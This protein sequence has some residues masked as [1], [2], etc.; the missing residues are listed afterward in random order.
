M[1]QA[2]T[3]SNMVESAA[4][5]ATGFVSQDNLINLEDTMFSQFSWTVS[6]AEF[7]PAYW[8]KARDEKLRQFWHSRGAG[9]LASAVYSAQSKLSSIPF[10]VVARDPSIASHVDE[11]AATEGRL[12]NLSE[13]GQG[14]EVTMSKFYEDL[15]STDN[16]G[17]IEVIGAGAPNGP[18]EGQ[19][20]ALRHLDSVRCT[21]TG[22]PVYPVRYRGDD[23]I[24]RKMHFSRIIYVSQMPSPRREL[25]G[26]GY[27]AVS[28]ALDFGQALMDV[29]LY[30]REKLGSR[31]TD[32]ILLGKGIRGED[33]M[34]TM[35]AAST[36][37]E[38]NGAKAGYW[39]ALGSDATDVGIEKVSLK[40]MDGMDETDVTAMSM[41]AI[42][43]AFGM[44]PSDLWPLDNASSKAG[45][46]VSLMRSRGKLPVQ[47][48]A[49]VEREFAFKV[50]PTYLKV[51]FSYI[52]DEEDKNR[53][54]VADIRARMRHR[55]MDAGVTNIQFERRRMMVSGDMSREE[56]VE[57]ELRDGR[58]ETG[59]PVTTLF[60][61]DNPVLTGPGGL[62][63]IGVEN[64]LAVSVN[65][66][67]KTIVA[68]NLSRERVLA[69]MANA[70][71]PRDRRT[72]QEAWAAINVLLQMYDPYFDPKLDLKPPSSDGNAENGRVDQRTER[73]GF[74]DNVNGGSV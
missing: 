8:S 27:C 57:A 47:V 1:A 7:V 66:I 9:H 17:F 3:Q 58:L 59:L 56:F 16:G 49:A 39:V 30:K 22:N 55:N 31:P 35:R 64:P 21:R 32:G 41:A 25:Y 2:Q 73:S 26:V 48:M 71:S 43:L 51:E 60:F 23:G 13:F 10:S 5:M 6:A 72:G 74:R 42:A 40:S 37:V 19:P 28:R 34:K 12:R 29:T 69:Y 11:A 20:F 61:S 15:L 18:I 14:L 45:E 67:D 4:Q 36:H 65:D 44:E 63:N 62:L 38:T 68:I 54:S 46:I 33:I 50:L 53:A 70:R 52:D 24:E